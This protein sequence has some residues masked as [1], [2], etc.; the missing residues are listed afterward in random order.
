MSELQFGLLGIGI[1]VVLAV[2]G[3][4]WWQQRQYQQRFGEAL[5]KQRPDVLDE[6]APVE[7]KTVDEL[8]EEPA[9]E[10]LA[11][12]VEQVLAEDAVRQNTV[13]ETCSLLDAATDY[14][15]AIYPSA[16]TSPAALAPLW[17]RRFDFGKKVHAC[18]LNSNTGIWEKVI[19]ESLQSYTAFKLALQLVDRSGAVSETRL[20]DF[21]D[22]AREIAEAIPA[23][24]EAPD[25]AHSAEL[26]RKLDAV[27]AEVDQ[28]IGL[29]LLP[30][31]ERQFTG[32][33][34]AQAV[35]QHGLSLQADGA[36]H[37]LDSDGRTLFT[38]SNMDNVTFQHHLL[39]QINTSGLTL[40]LEV[41]RVENPAGRF[42]EMLE[43]A[44]ALATELRASVV[45]DRRAVL[46]DAGIRLIRGQIDEIE[47]TMRAHQIVPGGP[48]ALRLFA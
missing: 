25:A 17:L 39:D 26:A 31:G 28:M 23:Q 34:V 48:L 20:N 5:E 9:A 21:C 42:A 46:G 33:Q 10:P 19:A 4:S 36:F 47:Q 24:V 6:P 15:V 30:R 7:E 22:L 37:L 2:Y 3:Y 32:S 1:A 8:L 16:P 27:C 35:R 14:L 18:G 44:R 41:P 43:L 45:D 11:D 38:L 12:E 13:D 29:N 40:L